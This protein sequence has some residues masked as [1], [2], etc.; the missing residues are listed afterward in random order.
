MYASHNVNWK[1]SRVRSK[2]DGQTVAAPDT[3]PVKQADESFLE[4]R[5]AAIIS[6]ILSSCEQTCL[7]TA[8]LV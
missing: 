3:P 8:C 2:I 4:S 5:S 7:Y 6:S 1:M